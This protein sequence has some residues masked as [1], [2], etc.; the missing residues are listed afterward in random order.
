MFEEKRIELEVGGKKVEISTGRLARQTTAGIEI[1]CEGTQLLVTVTK[2]NNIRDGI[3]YFPLMVDFEEKHYSVGKIPGSFNRREGRASDKGV[4]TSRLID[5]PIRPLFPDSFRNDLQVNAMTLSTNMDVP[6]DTLAMVGVGFAL[7]ISGLPFDGPISAVRVALDEDGNF[8]INPSEEMMIGNDLDLVV[9]GTAESVMMVEAGANF[10]PEDKMIEAIGFAHEEIKKHVVKMDEFRELCGVEKEVF[11]AP[12]VNQELLDI[13]AK[14]ATDDVMLS[15]KNATTK[16]IADPPMKAAKEKIEDAVVA[17]IDGRPEDDALVQYL[18]EK[19]TAIGDELKQL[20]KKILRKQILETGIRSDGRD[21]KTVRPLNVQVGLLDRV[22]G[23][24]LFTRGQTQVLSILTYGTERAARLLDGLDSEDHKYYMHN[25]NFPAWSVGEVRPNRG[26]GR[27][28]I[29]HGA[30]AERAIAPALPSREDFPYTM[31]VVSEVLESSGSTSMAATCGSSLA[32]MNGGVPLKQAIGG[33]AMGL[34]KGEDKHVVLTDIRDLEDFLGDMDFKVAG[35]KDGITALQMDIK[36]QGISME[37]ISDAIK[38][39]AG[40]R[41]TILEAMN[42]VLPE[43]AELKEN[44]P[45]IISTKINQEKIGAIIGSGGKTIKAISEK[46]E[47]EITIDDDGTVNIFSCSK[48]ACE[49]AREIV[50]LIANGVEVGDTYVGTI[51]KILDGVGA[52]V[53]IAPEV[54]GLV[55]ISEIAYERVEDIEKYLSVGDEVEVK[56]LNYDSFKNRTSLSIKAMK[57][58]PEGYVEKK[59]EPRGDGGGRNDRGRGGDRGG[60]GGDRGRS[61]GGRGRDSERSNV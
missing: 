41:K 44:A 58:A 60:R 3:D 49:A 25:Y 57:E 2:S 39:S 28:E 37:I 31:R 52:I 59:P 29:G 43:P 34:I 7:E 10:I 47:T 13:V 21:N 42:A 27:R 45:R 20:Q 5:R 15:I 56:V 14:V 8:I 6:P 50:E 17:A 38:A 9:A 26:P 33:V 35:G 22:H 1:S 16:E 48:E 46:T 51:A 36:V 40:G 18:E 30:L 23:D 11:V 61:G 24:G 55:H 4:L 53:E 54:S 12:T 32:L 19:P